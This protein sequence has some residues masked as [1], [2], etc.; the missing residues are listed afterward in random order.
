MTVYE[1]KKMLADYPDDL[2]VVNER[3]SDYEIIRIDDWY[4]VGGVDKDGWVMRSHPTMSDEN[5]VSEKL[6][7]C[8]KGN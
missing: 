1:L 5:K 6:Y 3:Y 7:L 8:L 4:I 2:Q